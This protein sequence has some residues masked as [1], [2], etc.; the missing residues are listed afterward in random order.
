[1]DKHLVFG[2][3][4]QPGVYRYSTGQ[5]P[6]TAERVL[7][8]FGGVAAD[9]QTSRWAAAQE[10][11]QIYVYEGQQLVRR[12]FLPSGLIHYRKGLLAFTHEDGW[13]CIA[14]QQKGKPD[15]GVWLYIC[16]DIENAQFERLFRWG[17][18]EWKEKDMP[19]VT[20]TDKDIND[21]AVGPWM[22]WPRAILASG[23]KTPPKKRPEASGPAK[24]S[25]EV[26]G[27]PK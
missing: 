21:F 12:L 2:S 17:P 19:D 4:G 14:C 16:Y 15:D 9:S 20:F 27:G 23:F 1:M 26:P 5:Q 3:G 6:D 7:P 11:D 22:P 24:Q 10:P 13:L 18:R 25:T 8:D